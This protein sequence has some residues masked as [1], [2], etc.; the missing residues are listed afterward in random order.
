[1]RAELAEQEVAE[2][3]VRRHPAAPRAPG[4]PR[5]PETR[6]AVLRAAHELLSEAGLANFTIE[7][8]ALRSGVARTT[9]YRWWPTKGAL[10][11]EGFLE[12][13]EREVRIVP[14]ESGVADMQ[15]QL[16]LFG[17]LLHGANG[18]IIRRIVAEGQDDP[19][20]LKAFLDGFVTP[21]RAAGRT[22]L[23]RAVEHGEIPADTDFDVMLT[24][25]Y[26]AIYTKLLLN[27]PFDDAWVDRLSRQVLQRP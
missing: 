23:R 1:M 25:L 26:G 21:R 12:A 17:R 10:A 11:M 16:R 5:C 24:S 7:A 2:P 15:Q 19:D 22:I 27:E 8:V 6:I 13:I 18:R 9:I 4:R 20:T 3:A 14:S